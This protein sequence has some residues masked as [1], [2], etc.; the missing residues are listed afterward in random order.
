MV[1]SDFLSRNKKHTNLEGCALMVCSSF[2]ECCNF[3]TQRNVSLSAPK[4][5]YFDS[6]YCSNQ[7]FSIVYFRLSD[8]CGGGGCVTDLIGVHTESVWVIS[9]RKRSLFKLPEFPHTLGNT[10][11]FER[12]TSWLS[13]SL[14]VSLV[15]I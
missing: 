4:I 9:R 8:N 3:G 1:T 6:Y 11:F 2:S 12:L 13:T 14:A 15:Q 5:K 10:G 7:L